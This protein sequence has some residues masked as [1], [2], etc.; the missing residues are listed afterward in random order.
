MK[1][2]SQTPISPQ[3][4]RSFSQARGRGFGDEG[5]DHK[6]ANDGGEA[7]PNVGEEVDGGGVEPNN[8]EDAE[9]SRSRRLIYH[10]VRQ[11]NSTGLTT[12]RIA[13]GVETALKAQ[14]GSSSM[15]VSR[16]LPLPV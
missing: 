10:H 1:P 11:L 6:A 8:P 4:P 14:E 12:G 13:V 5:Q 3:Y 15:A 7:Y 9:P 16:G 2:A